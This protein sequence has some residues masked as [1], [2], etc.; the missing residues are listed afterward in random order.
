[1]FDVDLG[2]DD[3]ARQVLQASLDDPHIRHAVS[4][5]RALR[6]DFERSAGAETSVAQ[7]I[8]S[9]SYGL[10][11][12]CMALGGLASTLSSPGSSGL[13]SV[14][15]C[16]QLFISI[17]QV[18]QD[19][20]AMAQHI[21]QGLTIMREYRARPNLADANELL[22]AHHDQ[23]PL[24]DVFVIKLFAAPRKFAE[25]SGPPLTADTSGRTVSTC[26]TAPHQQP[27]G[28]R[29]LRT[30]APDMRTQLTRIAASTLDFLGRVSR[31]KSVETALKLK[32]EKVALLNSLRLWLIGLELVQTESRP[33]SAELL[34][35]SFMRLFHL[36]LKIV[37][38]GTLGLSPDL[39]AK[40][41]VENGRL[42]KVANGVGE[43]VQSHTWMKSS[44]RAI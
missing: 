16:C 20:A 32:S 4:S 2:C 5:L 10:Q 23:L 24:L 36:I 18:R 12:Y 21:I 3:E 26:L 35:V 19:Y 34:S 14:L 29:N 9:Y 22:P 44:G 40:L 15:H 7:Q 1:M 37:L 17:E 28:I 42:Q 13:K 43:R 27:I 31:V 33:P 25:P 30:I 39:E 11:Q 6:K 8:P 41:R 38:L